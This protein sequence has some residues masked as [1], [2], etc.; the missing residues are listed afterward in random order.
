MKKPKIIKYFP[1][2][3]VK[4]MDCEYENLEQK[5]VQKGKIHQVVMH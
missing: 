3:I 2:I 1:P 5:F 4:C